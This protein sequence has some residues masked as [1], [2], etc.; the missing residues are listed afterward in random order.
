MISHRYL[1]FRSVE[2]REVASSELCLWWCIG[3][4]ASSDGVGRVPRGTLTVS[5]SSC[6]GIAVRR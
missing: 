4:K 3:E 1:V 2:R 6:G 5:V